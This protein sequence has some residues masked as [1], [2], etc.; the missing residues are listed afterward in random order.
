MNR[1]D[2]L[3]RAFSS[4]AGIHKYKPGKHSEFKG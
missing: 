1:S 2:F 4:G 3:K